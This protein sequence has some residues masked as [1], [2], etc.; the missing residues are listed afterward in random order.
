MWLHLSL[1]FEEWDFES[2]LKTFVLNIIYLEY[3]TPYKKKKKV[4][5]VSLN[6]LSTNVTMHHDY[7]CIVFA[8]LITKFCGFLNT[9]NL[10]GATNV[11]HLFLIWKSKLHQNWHMIKKERF[12]IEGH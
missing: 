1:I 6:V 7:Y 2:L 3:F 5:V 4:S 12:T 8:R 10:S 11:G 9:T